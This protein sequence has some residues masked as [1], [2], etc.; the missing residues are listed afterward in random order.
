MLLQELY[1]RLLS[2]MEL[3]KPESMDSIKQIKTNRKIKIKSLNLI[4][5][6]KRQPSVT[7]YE[8]ENSKLINQFHK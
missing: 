5:D 4:Q 6:N 8:N 3:R 7:N 1:K 2:T